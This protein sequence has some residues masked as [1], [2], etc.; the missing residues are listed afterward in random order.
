ML[1]GVVRR[2]EAEGPSRAEEARLFERG[3]QVLLRSGV[4]LH[5]I[6][7]EREQVHR[8]VSLDG[9]DVG[10]ARIRLLEGRPE[11]LVHVVVE[12]IRVVERG[13]DSLRGR[14]FYVPDALGQEP[15]AI[16]GHPLA[17]AGGGIR[18]DELRRAATREEDEY[19]FGPVRLGPRDV[20]AGEIRLEVLAGE[21]DLD[22]VHD[23]PAAL[24][25]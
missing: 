10:L 23:G 12:G 24:L 16:E 19:R 20:E 5:F 18:L 7:G 9:I 4:A 11:L 13:L 2:G 3:D 15:A 25:E 8:V 21:G 14:T 1:D 22:L 17:Q 6:E